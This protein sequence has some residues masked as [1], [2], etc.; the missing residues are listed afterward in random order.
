[1]SSIADEVDQPKYYNIGKIPVI[2]FIE[3]QNLNFSR[4]SAVKYICRAEHKGDELK[5]LYKAKWLINRE[6]QRL[7]GVKNNE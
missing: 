5:D 2:D 1:M 3:D 4:G 6:I 7:E